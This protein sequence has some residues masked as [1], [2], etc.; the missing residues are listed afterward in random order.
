[1]RKNQF[2]RRI[3]AWLG[4][5]AVIFSF[6]FV[7]SLSATH[8]P[9]GAQGGY[10]SP[11]FVP[12]PIGNGGKAT[13][14]IRSSTFTSQYPKGF[15]FDLDANSSGGKIVSARVSWQHTYFGGRTSAKGDIDS[16]GENATASWQ[17]GTNRESVPQWVSVEYWWELTDA[18]G[19]KFV[20]D[21]QFDEYADNTRKWNRLES[22]D[23]LVFWEDSVPQEIGQLVIDAVSERHDFYVKMW[24]KLLPYRPRVIIYND[25]RSWEEWLPG[26]SSGIKGIQGITVPTWGGTAQRYITKVGLRSTAYGVVL[27]EIAHLYQFENGGVNRYRETW[28]LEGNA[29]F[30]EI[31]QDYDYLARVQKLAQRGSLQGLEDMAIRIQ[32]SNDPRLPYDVGYAF[33]VWLTETYGEDAHLKLWTLLGQGRSGLDSL[34]LVTGMNFTDMEVAFRTWLGAKNPRLP[35]PLPTVLPLFPPTPTPFVPSKP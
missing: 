22:A 30:F 12:S 28:F 35:T 33:F 6:T 17:N 21:H 4:L 18:A 1:M 2:R 31:A 16:A 15:R 23:V 27:H 19:N 25:G 34:Q 14:T 5:G 7:L 9:A 20:T 11:T 29:T 3:A 24:G 32:T 8:L 26:L 13:W 10:P